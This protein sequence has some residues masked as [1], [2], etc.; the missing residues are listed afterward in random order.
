V[1]FHSLPYCT[2]GGQQLLAR[3]AA[4]LGASQRRFDETR[5]N[6]IALDLLF[7]TWGSH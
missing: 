2:R 7:G 3:D 6:R 4:R 5:R 1:A